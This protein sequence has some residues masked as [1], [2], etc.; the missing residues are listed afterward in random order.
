MY[1]GHIVVPGPKMEDTVHT[2]SVG[3]REPDNQHDTVIVTVGVD[4]TGDVVLEVLLEILRRRD[5]YL[6]LFSPS[7]QHDRPLVVRWDFSVVE[8]S[9]LVTGV[10]CRRLLLVRLRPNI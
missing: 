5:G 2:G 4:D 3:H 7:L 6:F 9:F 10:S 8:E 1:L